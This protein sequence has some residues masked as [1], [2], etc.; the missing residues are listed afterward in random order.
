MFNEYDE[1]GVGIV[2]RDSGG[3]VVAAMAEKIKKPLSV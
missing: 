2:I 1:A 3:M